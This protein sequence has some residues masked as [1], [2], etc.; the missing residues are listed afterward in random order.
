MN[1]RIKIIAQELN[2]DTNELINEHNIYEKI[3]EVPKKINNL[4]FTH[5]EQIAILG[6]S[7]NAIIQARSAMINENNNTGSSVSPQ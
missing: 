3:A 6:K 2:I 1:T 4:G 7:Q 5:K